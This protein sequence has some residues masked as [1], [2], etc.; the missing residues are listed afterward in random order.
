MWG[1]IAWP[2][3]DD[4]AS[5]NELIA[6]VRDPPWQRAAFV[7]RIAV[8]G[9]LILACVCLGVAVGR[10]PRPQLRR[11]GRVAL[12]VGTLTLV[13]VA[14]SRLT[15]LLGSATNVATAALLVL[16]G[17]AWFMRGLVRRHGA[18]V[19]AVAGAT[20][21][22]TAAWLTVDKA[23]LS[24]PVSSDS[25]AFVQVGVSFSVATDTGPDVKFAVTVAGLFLTVAM[26]V[27]SCARLSADGGEAR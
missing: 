26:T 9:C 15:G 2:I 10:L 4:A 16:G 13:L 23:R 20:V 25:G 21:L 19:I 6:L 14:L 5:T 3:D 12:P 7:R 8:S 22:A 27:L 1:W 24:Q 18:A 11:I 17:Y